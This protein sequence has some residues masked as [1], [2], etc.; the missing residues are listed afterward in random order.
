MVTKCKL[1]QNNKWEVTIESDGNTFTRNV[2]HV[3]VASGAH[4]KPF[5]PD[6][7]GFTGDAI[8]SR[9]WNEE[10]FSIQEK[11]QRALFWYR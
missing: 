3:V 6:L 5:I 7:A 2:D 4:M 8:H 11:K 1:N 9:N 10:K